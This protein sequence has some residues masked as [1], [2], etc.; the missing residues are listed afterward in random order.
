[1][2][3]VSEDLPNFGMAIAAAILV[4]VDVWVVLSLVA[5]FAGF[6]IKVFRIR[7]ADLADTGA[8]AGGAVAD[9]IGS[10]A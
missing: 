6:A 8:S 7:R 2:S 1:M 3:I 4:K 5:T 10:V 9:V